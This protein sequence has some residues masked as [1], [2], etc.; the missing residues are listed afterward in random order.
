MLMRKKNRMTQMGARVRLT[1]CFRLS[2]KKFTVP[3]PIN[4]MLLPA[5]KTTSTVPTPSDK[6]DDDKDDDEDDDG[7]DTEDDSPIQTNNIK[8]Q[9]TKIPRNIETVTRTSLTESSMSS[10]AIFRNEMEKP[11]S[12]CA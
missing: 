1:I 4:K 8:K 3:S 7:D 12:P 11:G 2:K 6:I 5:A 9:E 10:D